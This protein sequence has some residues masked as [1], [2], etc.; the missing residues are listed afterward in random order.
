MWFNFFLN[1]TSLSLTKFIEKYS[2]IFNKK[3]IIKIYSL[4]DLVKL[5]DILDVTNF[6]I[7]IV[8]LY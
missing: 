5:I 7:N 1:H 3:Y 4:L 2:N 8:K 6:F